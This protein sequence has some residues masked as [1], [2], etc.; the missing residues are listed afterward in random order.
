MGGFRTISLADATYRRLRSEKRP[1]ESFADV[2]ERLL[3]ARQPPLSKHLGAWKAMSEEEYRE[4]RAKLDL[5]RH[6]NPKR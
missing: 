4:I 1:G 3:S 2:I 6:G 5:I